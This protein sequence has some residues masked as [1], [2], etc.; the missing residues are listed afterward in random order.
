MTFTR[1]LNLTAWIAFTALLTAQTASAQTVVVMPRVHH[2]MPMGAR[3]GSTVVLTV[4]GQ[5]FGP[6]SGL[7]FS[8][9]GARVEVY[10]RRRFPLEASRIRSPLKSRVKTR[11][12]AKTA[13]L[14]PPPSQL[15]E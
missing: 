13:V 14:P 11:P 12:S 2:V 6:V 4:T 10:V 8:F 5:D 7:H 15:V 3:A 9:A 1:P